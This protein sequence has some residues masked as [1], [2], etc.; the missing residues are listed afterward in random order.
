MS[1]LADWIRSTALAFGAPGL[2]VV[3]FLDSSFLSLPE[4]NDLLLIWMVTQHKSRMVLYAGAATLG[5]IAGCLVLYYIGRKGGDA[6]V[7]RR[8]NTARVDWALGIMQRHGVLAVLIPSLLPPPAPFKI[9]VLLAGVAHISAARFAIAIGIGRG[10]R[11]FAEGLLA[12]W[13]GDQALGYLE[14]NLRTVS[15]VV[16]GLLVAGVAGYLVWSRARGA[17]SR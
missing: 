1:R 17:K 11:Y 3:A 13:Y 7:R 5:S 16:V 12:V 8:F 15:L 6:L 14:E 9:F 10:L 2:F 4:I